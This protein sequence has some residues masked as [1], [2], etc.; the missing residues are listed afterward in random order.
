MSIGEWGAVMR[1]ARTAT[2][3][4][5]Q[6]ENDRLRAQHDEASGK[7]KFDNLAYGI[8]L[9]TDDPT[10]ATWFWASREETADICGVSEIEDVAIIM[11]EKFPPTA[12]EA[13]RPDLEMPRVAVLLFKAKGDRCQRCWKYV[14]ASGEEV[15]ER[16]SNVLEAA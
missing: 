1:L 11:G 9:Y 14:A 10:S 7:F 16:C 6:M 4:A 2:K 3:K 15:C 12:A 5:L 8:M 13:E